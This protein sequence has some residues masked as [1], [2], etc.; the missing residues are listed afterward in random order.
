MTKREITTDLKDRLNLLTDY[1]ELLEE[2]ASQGSLDFDSPNVSRE[3][4]E[5][6][7]K[8]KNSLRQN[9]YEIY[10][11]LSFARFLFNPVCDYPCCINIFGKVLQEEPESQR[12][13]HFIGKILMNN[14]LLRQAYLLFDN[15][16]RI[17]RSEESFRLP[18]F[19]Y[20]FHHDLADLGSSIHE[21]N[22]SLSDI[23]FPVEQLGFRFHKKTGFYLPE[24]DFNVPNFDH[25][26]V[27]M[28]KGRDRT[29][30]HIHSELGSK[31]EI[32]RMSHTEY[33]CP[34]LNYLKRI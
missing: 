30:M 1:Q 9:P 14:K 31:M 8:H 3:D 19:H 18:D 27:G 23:G 17:M 16:L 33:N 32:G 22:H 11:L 26:D 28:D 10:N 5:E 13:N 4:Q 34:Y 15:G 2:I 21:A 6:Y 25:T 7:E 24:F 12:A 29:L 20:K